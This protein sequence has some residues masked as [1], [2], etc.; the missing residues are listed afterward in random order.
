MNNVIL[1][2]KDDLNYPFSGEPSFTFRPRGA[3]YSQSLYISDLFPCYTH[4]I[5]L[6]EQLARECEKKFPIKFPISYYIVP[7]EDKS[8]TNGYAAKINLYDARKNKNATQFAPYIVLWGKRIP[9]HPAM[10]RYLVSHEAG[11]QIQNWIEYCRGEEDTC[12]ASKFER[13]YAKMRKIELFE[14]Y[15]GLKW[16]KNIKEIIANDI[17][18][19]VFGAEREFWPHECEHPDN[20]RYVHDFWYE[21]MLSY[22]YSH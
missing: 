16:H 10:T 6:V 14:G 13:E 19:C 4:D 5:Q 22:S 11:H 17:R 21:I 9:I 1:F 3:D 2:N 18:I 7:F 8:R 15:G 12:G 20:L